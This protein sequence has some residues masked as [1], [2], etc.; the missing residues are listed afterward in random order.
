MT[1]TALRRPAP[2][3]A[4]ALFVLALGLVTFGL[5][6]VY[7]SSGFIDARS[8]RLGHDA[9]FHFFSLHLLSIEDQK[10]NMVNFLQ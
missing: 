1:T 4:L 6:M 8:S 10:M 3:S 5:V 7:S 2:P 9:F